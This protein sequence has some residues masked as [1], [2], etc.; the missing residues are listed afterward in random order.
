[1]HQQPFKDQRAATA[2]KTAIARASS[3]KENQL[4]S[5]SCAGS[6]ICFR[7]MLALFISLRLAAKL[8]GHRNQ[9]PVFW[10]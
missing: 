9:M 2:S 10:K 7:K 5:L 8:I 6:D 1:V 3:S 4:L